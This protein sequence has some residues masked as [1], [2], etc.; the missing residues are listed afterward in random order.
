M[1][2]IK[3]II[4]ILII[5]FFY[6]SFDLESRPSNVPLTAEYDEDLEC[7]T[8]RIGK[9]PNQIQ[10]IWEDDGEIGSISINDDKINDTTYF[11]KGRWSLRESYNSNTLKFIEKLPP[12]DKPDT[13]PKKSNFNFDFRK[14]ESGDTTSSK[15]NGIWTLWWPSGQKAGTIEYTSDIYNGWL[16]MDWENGNRKTEVKYVNGKRKGVR[17][18]YYENGMLLEKSNYADGNLDGVMEIYNSEGELAR[19]VIFDKGKLIKRTIL[20]ESEEEI[21]ERLSRDKRHKKF[22]NELKK[23]NVTESRPE[24]SKN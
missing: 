14:W 5:L 21:K 9:Y 23:Q 11:N 4:I 12:I 13:I 10:I 20:R 24:P 18:D 16:K 2:K 15:K 22:F 3:N 17:L 6:L 7:Y 1:I 19:I 8:L